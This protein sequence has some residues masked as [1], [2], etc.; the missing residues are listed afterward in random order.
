MINSITQ[1][2]LEAAINDTKA[3]I[4]S[5]YSPKTA[6]YYH[7]TLEKLRVYS[8]KSLDSPDKDI[9][10]F[11]RLTAKST[12]YERPE[13]SWLR[14]QARAILILIDIINGREPA[15][16][17]YYRRYVYNGTFSNELATFRDWR[18][19]NGMST[20]TIRKETRIVTDFLLFLEKQGVK[21]LLQVDGVTLLNFLKSI[22]TGYS[23]Q[24]IRDHAYTVRKFLECPALGIT[25]GFDI[26]PLLSGF[27]HNKNT[28]LES[29]YTADEIRAVMNAVKRDTPWGKTIYAMMLLACVYGL[30]VS[31]IRELMFS[32]I[33]WK[34]KTITLYQKKTKRFVELPLID[35]VMLAILD[36]IKNVRPQSDD[37]HVF[38]R[39][40]A[41]CV[42]YSS[43]DNFGSKISHYFKAA[44]IDTTGKHHG[45]H[46]MRHSLATNLLAENTATNEIAAI[47]GHAT[48]KSTKPYIWSDMEH[49]RLAALEVP[50][51]GK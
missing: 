35:E 26:T 1:D 13:T 25:F 11:Y 48:V 32:S 31:D 17:Y 46:S 40:I 28:R 41:P 10:A 6:S 16:E 39:H 4:D 5:V 20:E 9:P 14:T 12:A 3:Y 27:R 19:S 33:H 43:K 38:L 44:G 51:Y 36:Y 23:D 47:L 8:M 30:R 49:L 24:W 45:F 21:H 15:R 22:N 50:E 37:P 34:S 7:G 29:Y 42:P 2:E 18:I